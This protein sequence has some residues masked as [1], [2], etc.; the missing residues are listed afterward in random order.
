MSDEK[1]FNEENEENEVVE[2]NNETEETVA[3]ETE[4]ETEIEVE[5][6]VTEETEDAVAEAVEDAATKATG[7]FV[8]SESVESVLGDNSAGIDNA[9]TN[10]DNNNEISEAVAAAQAAYQNVEGY[11]QKKSGKGSVIAVIVAAV[12]VVALIVAAI[13]LF[14]PSLFN[15]YNRQGY[16][17]VSGRTIAEVAEESGMDVSEFLVQYGLPE[18]MPGNTTEAAA[19]NNIPLSNMATMYGMD[20]TTMKDILQLPEDVTE[21][22]PWGEAIG[23]TTLGAYVGEDNLA[24][25]KETFGFGD[26]ITTDTL[27]SEVRGTIDQKNREDRIASEKAAKESTDATDEDVVDTADIAE[28]EAPAEVEATPAA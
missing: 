22:T 21:E 17:D 26:E 16:V 18:D 7:A 11:E 14:G 8:A 25:F 6:T 4:V 3:E 27:W 10:A 5:D 12:L 20:V 1:N 24:E 23:K 28:T 13:F 19:Y 2:S 15:K 9:D